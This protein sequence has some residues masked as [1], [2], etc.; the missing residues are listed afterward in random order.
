MYSS[1]GTNV[2]DVQ[3]KIIGLH[4]QFASL[5]GRSWPQGFTGCWQDG[6]DVGAPGDIE[7]SEVPFFQYA[8]MNS[9]ALAVGLLWQQLYAIINNANIIINSENVKP[10]EKAEAQFFR[11]Y[12][13]DMLVTLWGKVPLI[14]ESTTTP[15]TNYTRDEISKVDELIASDLND[16]IANLPEV[17]QT[18]TENRI[19]KDCARILAGQ[20]FL[21]M[22]KNAEAEKAVTD[23]IEG[24]KYSLIQERYGNFLADAGDYYSDMFRWSNQRRSQGNTE[25]IWIFQMEY[26]NTV[27]GGTID[28]PQQRRNYVAA[29]H[30]IEGMV[31]AD[32]LGGRGNGRL[33]LSNYVKYGVYEEGDIRNSNHNIRRNLYYNKPGFEADIYIDADGYKVAEETEGATKIH[34]KTG[35]LVHISKDDTLAVMYPHTT[36]WG[37]Y[38]VND[39]F[40][41]ALIKDW[42]L[43]RLADAYLL[44][45]EARVQQGNAQG[46]ADDINVLRDRAFKDYRAEKGDDNLGKVSA[47]DMDM[48]FILDER[49]R[50]LVGEENRRYTLCRTKKLADRVKMMM[51]SLWEEKVD[52]KKI[53][54]FDE[55]IHTLLPIPLSE[56]QLNKDANLE[57]NPGYK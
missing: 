37:G 55:N 25:G 44:R 39:D 52:A 7:G 6:T 29:F 16:A 49:I 48:D 14:T 43:M 34:V 51:T 13:Y 8:S 30:K 54:G 11:A 12:S 23:V 56:I 36:K 27:P 35:D 26:N 45:A 42:P 33:R 5:W 17:D 20:A 31:N 28:A 19:N 38:D 24:G 21:R 40:G 53:T 2:N 4:Y 22:G 9:E 15:K 3:A 18:V 32:S 10:E 50:E 41:W 57:Q 1:Y 47:S 46:A